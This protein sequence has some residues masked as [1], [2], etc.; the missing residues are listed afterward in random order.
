MQQPADT[1]VDDLK[2]ETSERTDLTTLRRAETTLPSSST[3]ANSAVTSQKK[4]SLRQR[5][6]NMFSSLTKA[7]EGDHEFHNYLGG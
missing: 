6:K 4:R 3:S 7:L 1:L 2:N 5:I